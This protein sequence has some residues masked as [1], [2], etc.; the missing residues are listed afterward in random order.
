MHLLLSEKLRVITLSQ[1]LLHLRFISCKNNKVF[2]VQ[3]LV[4]LFWKLN[5]FI[6][7]DLK[8]LV[9]ERLIL[10]ITSLKSN[11]LIYRQNIFVGLEGCRNPIELLT[12]FGT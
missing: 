7:Q 3:S 12:S 11:P 8:T 2:E 4:I 10:V 9:C 1:G 6:Q 5:L